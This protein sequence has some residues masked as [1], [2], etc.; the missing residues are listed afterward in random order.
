[1]IYSDSPGQGGNFLAENGAQMCSQHAVTIGSGYISGILT[2]NHYEQFP[3]TKNFSEVTYFF[4]FNVIRL[5][6]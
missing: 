1:M 4:G 3:W 5:Y 2:Q 6:R